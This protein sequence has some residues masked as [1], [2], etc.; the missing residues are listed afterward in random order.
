MLQANFKLDKCL[1]KYYIIKEID[2]KWN[3][4]KTAVYK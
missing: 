2:A 1:S 3:G 4:S